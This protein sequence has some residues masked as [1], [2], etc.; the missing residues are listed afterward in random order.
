MLIYYQFPDVHIQF[1]IKNKLI[2]IV[3]VQIYKQNIL[4]YIDSKH[5]QQ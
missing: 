5:Q 4:K 1:N 2:V 3:M